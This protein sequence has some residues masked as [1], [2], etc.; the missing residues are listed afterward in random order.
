MTDTLDTLH[1]ENK[2]RPTFLTVLCILTFITTGFNLVAGLFNVVI[3]GR[4]SEEAMLEAKVQM[5]ESVTGLKELGMTSF[6]DFM[7]KLERMTVEINDNFY[8]AAIVSLITVAI[9]LFSALK[10]WKGFK[11]G[12]HL[13]IVYNLLA[14]AGIYLYVSPGNIPS[15][16]VIVNVILSAI[17]VFMYSRNLHWMTK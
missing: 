1:E 7:E 6:V 9:G 3:T 2:R 10:M 8:M 17:F 14:I 16:V 4:Q 12:F 5:A 15:F 13:Y 11:V